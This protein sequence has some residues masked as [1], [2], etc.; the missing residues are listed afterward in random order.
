MILDVKPGSV[1]VTPQSGTAWIAKPGDAMYSSALMVAS[2]HYI[3]GRWIPVE[4][5]SY[6]KPT[7]LSMREQFTFRNS[8]VHWLGYGV[9][10][11]RQPM[12]KWET[13]DS[14][15]GYVDVW[16]RCEELSMWM[17][18]EQKVVTA[19]RSLRHRLFGRVEFVK[20]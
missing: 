12:Q 7:F 6:G 17:S 1:M 5:I 20:L 19:T 4:D 18:A 13:A 3:H 11:N 2:H 16:L 8:P 9:T 15:R 14:V 10:L